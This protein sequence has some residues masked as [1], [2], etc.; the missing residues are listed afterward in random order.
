MTLLA[1]LFFIW[2][3]IHIYIYTYEAHRAQQLFDFGFRYL[4]IC[5][6]F[7]IFVF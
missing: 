5:G 2:A 4:D 1:Y 6:L 7:F 3:Y